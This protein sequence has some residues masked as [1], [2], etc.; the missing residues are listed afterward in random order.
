MLKFFKIIGCSFVLSSSCW[1]MDT[2][3]S[4]F[5]IENASYDYAQSTKKLPPKGHFYEPIGTLETQN[6]RETN[7][8]IEEL[9][10]LLNVAK[11]I[12]IR[13]NFNR[14]A[15]QVQE[16]KKTLDTETKAKDDFRSTLTRFHTCI[17][18]K[19]NPNTFVVNSK[20]IPS[21]MIPFQKACSEILSSSPPLK[22]D[23]PFKG[24][25]SIS[26]QNTAE[27]AGSKEWRIGLSS[28]HNTI[29]A[30]QSNKDLGLDVKY[31]VRARDNVNR[32]SNQVINL[33]E[34]IN[35]AVEGR[36]EDVKKAACI[37]QTWTNATLNFPD[38]FAAINP[39]KFCK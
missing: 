36:K 9:S 33:S 27:P 26:Y 23:V 6:G 19:E 15:S 11:N 8:R 14:M 32:V 20:D 4:I 29:Y 10:P 31:G 3:T 24:L 38:K 1:S 7:T 21:C 39:F 5:N 22:N 30:L 25:P 17:N 35:E 34:K 13:D 12:R 37:Y 16:L 28:V 18:S 2:D